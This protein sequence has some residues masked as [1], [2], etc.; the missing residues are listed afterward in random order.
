[1]KNFKTY[2]VIAV[3]IL[4]LTAILM[5]VSCTAPD[6][7]EVLQ[8]EKTAMATI[9]NTGGSPEVFV[10]SNCVTTRYATPNL[11]IEVKKGD[12][13]TALGFSYSTDNSNNYGGTNVN[14][15]ANITIQIDN[16]T[17]KTGV[18]HCSYQFN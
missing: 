1:M 5:N 15:T 9:T 4:M 12:V 16:K 3:Y 18:G 2:L 7:E 17:V 10:T 14:V 6:N 11:N 13:I 8:I